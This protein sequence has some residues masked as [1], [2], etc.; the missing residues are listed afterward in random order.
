ML[1]PCDSLPDRSQQ[2]LQLREDKPSSNPNKLT[3]NH[4][5][6]SLYFIYCSVNLNKQ[7]PK[8]IV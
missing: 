7:K 8:R 6:V 2:E 5:P 1:T 3:S 4:P